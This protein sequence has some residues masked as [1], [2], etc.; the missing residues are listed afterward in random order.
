MSDF[1]KFI[2]YS[3]GIFFCYTLV[4][5]V[6][7]YFRIGLLSDD[8]LNFYDALNSTLY[9]K[10]TGQLPFS[11][12][13]HIRPL[14][15]L[16]LE[17]SIVLHD[18]FGFASDNFIFYR[19]Q[20]LMLFFFTVFTAGCISLHLTKRISIALA[21]VVSILLF[22]NN[23][24]NICWVSAR[25]DLICSFFYLMSIYLFLLYADY[26]KRYFF[27]VSI[28]TFILA[29]LT[30]ELAVTLPATLTLLCY[31][32]YGKEGLKSNKNLLLVSG[33]ILLIYFVFKFLVLG[34][35]ITGITTIYQ[36]TPLSNAPGVFA[37]GF[38]S[39]TIPIDY[40]TLNYLLRNDNKIILLYLFTLYGAGIYLIW[41]MV[42]ADLSKYIGQLIA[43]FFLLITPYAI[44]GYIR[45]QMILLPFIIITIHL[46]YLYSRQREVSPK[47]N[48]KIL[49]VFFLAAVIFW[50]YWSAAAVQDW[51]TSYEKSKINVDNL[52]KVSK[53]P[54][55]RMILIGNPG[56]YKQTF[57]FDKM[58]GAYNFWKTGKFTIKDTINDIVQT[59]ALE[60]GS[61][62]AKLELKILA[63]NEFE[64]RAIAP[65]HFFY[66]EGLD[67]ESIRGGFLNND[68][69][70]E[71]TEFNN[72]NKPIRLKLKIL[73][74]DVE[75]YLAENLDFRKIY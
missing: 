29:L 49:K 18:M 30:K 61:I 65:K 12:A 56:R 27:A 74:G 3:A 71:F 66:I 17:K 44:V 72:I 51:L 2:L 28:I 53:E 24:S 57:M 6:L 45:P 75:C 20:N 7:G 23:I 22:S 5:F 4:L 50:S 10:A 48:R 43:L 21:A 16:S 35:S 67:N 64:I 60:E 40:L 55:K 68:I 69:S 34:S 25:A 73:S 26:R 39:L 13:F 63:P 70:V 62:G 38:L 33:G 11:N 42:K 31:F 15:H 1:R 14:Y 19:I 54:G 37:R 59:A 47:L 32:I 46:L 9:Q 58:T 52:I 8:Y 41:V 36:D